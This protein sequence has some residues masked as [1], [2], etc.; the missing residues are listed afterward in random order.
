MARAAASRRVE[1]PRRVPR[2]APQ[3]RPPILDSRQALARERRRRAAH[4]RRR[5]RDLLMDAG[6]GLALAIFVIV[7]TTGLGAVALLLVPTVMVLLAS[8]VVERRRRRRR[9]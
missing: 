8:V 6:F 5:R 9:S 3:E 2:P 7:R 4:F 1:V